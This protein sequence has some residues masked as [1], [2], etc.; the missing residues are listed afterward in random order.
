MTH[1]YQ[2]LQGSKLWRCVAAALAALESNQDLRIMTARPHV[3]GYICKRL[4][5]SG[6][7]YID[8]RTYASRASR[9]NKH[10]RPTSARR[11][12]KHAPRRRN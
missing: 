12:P 10:L 9:P 7:R 5:R 11:S 6:L 4:E 1:P 3:I 8:T 2:A